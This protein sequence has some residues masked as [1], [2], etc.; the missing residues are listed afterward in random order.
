MEKYSMFDD[1]LQQYDGEYGKLFERFAQ[2]EVKANVTIDPATQFMVQIG[3]I[4][5]AQGVD[6]YRQILPAALK[7]LGPIAIKEII[8]QAGAYLG[9]SKVYPFLSVT[10]EIFL[11]NNI[12]LPL[13]SQSTT[14]K[15]SRQKEG[16]NAQV[17]IF[18]EA[19]A[20]FYQKGKMNYLLAANC[21]GDYYTRTGLDLKSRELLTFSFLLGHGGCE[22]QL[23]SHV[24]G[25]LKMGNDYSTMMD[26]IY[27]CLPY[28]G[29]PRSLNAVAVLNQV[30]NN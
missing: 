2:E 24:N 28:V 27:V 18:G 21:F 19:M 15:T 4:M 1:L 26:V 11:A 13:E 5:A 10:N 20:D 30:T 7:A 14:D 22:S 16:T 25:N 8:Y 9:L 23:A 12:A 6:C 17:A 29:Y 3:A